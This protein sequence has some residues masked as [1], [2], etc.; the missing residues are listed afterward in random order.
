MLLCKDKY[1]HTC[2]HAH[3]I[4]AHYMITTLTTDKHKTHT[5][6]LK[7]TGD[8]RPDVQ[9]ENSMNVVA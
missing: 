3:H 5:D 6:A 8:S 7:N 2:A 4:C 9:G 1:T